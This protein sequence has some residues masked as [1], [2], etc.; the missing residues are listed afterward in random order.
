MKK[1]ILLLT[2]ILFVFSCTKEDCDCGIIEGY[3]W[4]YD[5]GEETYYLDIRNEC[6]GEIENDIQVT[7]NWF[8]ELLGSRKCGISKNRLN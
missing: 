7:Q 3:D 6:T 1:L 8:S 2:V 5:T 4:K